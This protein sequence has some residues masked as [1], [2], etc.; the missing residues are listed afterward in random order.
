MNLP[1]S[2]CL[3]VLAGLLPASAQPKPPAQK[4]NIILI[5]SDDV[6][7]GDIGCCGGPFKTPQIDSLAKGGTRFEYCYSTPLC[8]PV[9]L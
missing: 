1:L 6:G 8:G 7:L 4:P 3:C 2:L 5:Y 9:A